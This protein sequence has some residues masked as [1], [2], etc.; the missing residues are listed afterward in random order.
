MPSPIVFNRVTAA[1]PDGT[2]CLH[3]VTATFS[4]GVTGVV[5]SNG[6]G[7]TTL[8]R[9]ISGDLRPTSGTV[10]VGG[11]VDVLP[12]NLT[13]ATDATVAD[14]LGIRG[15]VDAIRAVEG[16]DSDP[17][18]FD[19]IGDGWDVEARAAE[20]LAGVGLEFELDRPVGTLSGGEAMLAAVVGLRVRGAEIALLDEPTNNLDAATRARVYDLLVRWRGTVLVVSHDVGLLRRV[21]QIAE[22]RGGGVALYGGSWDE[23]QEAVAVERAAAERGVRAAEAQLKVEKRQRI[24]AEKR[25]ARRE[26]AGRAAIARGMEKVQRDY[27]ANRSTRSVGRERGEADDK[28]AAARAAVDE[29]EARLRDDERVRIDLPDPE[30]GASRR[31]AELTDATGREHVIQGPERVALVGPNGVGKTLLLESLVGTGEAGRVSTRLPADRVGYLPQR[32]DHLDDAASLLGAVS[33]AAPGVEPGLI[34]NRLARFGLRGDA[35]HRPLGTL[36]GGERFRASLAALLLAE[37][38]AQILIL[39]EPTNNLD[40]ATVDVL[41]DALASYRGALL[42][43]SHDE[44]F[45]ERLGVHRTLSLGADGS[46][47]EHHPSADAYCGGGANWSIG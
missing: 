37:P 9:L 21:G 42:V 25:L 12:Q 4:G 17:A 13:L 22:V 24:E 34:R 6:A 23:Y 20:E 31:L 14:L 46:L 3:D 10:T 32:L 38:P 39:D 30:V 41:V 33:A 1:W 35:V 27:F 2:V 7:K 8:L 28:V 19:T 15:V 11:A 44:H 26:S 45:L 29:A 36:S 47:T 40:L 16:G 18:H 43:V 5:G